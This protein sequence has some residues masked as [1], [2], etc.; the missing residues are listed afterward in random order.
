MSDEQIADYYKLKQ[1]YND[2]LKRLK[3]RI[4]RD[5]NLSTGEKRARVRRIKQECVGCKRN[6]GTVFAVDGREL[7]A[8]C[9]RSADPCDLNIRIPR[10]RYVDIRSVLARYER[11]LEERRVDVIRTKLD[12]LFG[13]IDE[14]S[15]LEQFE[16][17]KE[18]MSEQVRSVDLLTDVYLGI[19][20]NVENEPAIRDVDAD[21]FVVKEEL[22][23]LVVEYKDS[24]R[25]SILRDIVDLYSTRLLPAAQK[26]RALKYSE[27]SVTRSS[28]GDVTLNEEPFT[29]SRLLINLDGE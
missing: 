5:P 14:S 20:N 12:L 28:S 8:T 26:L 18:G 6:G 22:R 17:L 15:A 1:K 10:G 9:G 7:V 29:L 19:V 25:D 4:I 27:S 16:S 24:G 23:R 3:M 2:K 21:L 11:R 13:S